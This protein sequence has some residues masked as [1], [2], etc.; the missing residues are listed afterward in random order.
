MIIFRPHR[1]MLSDAMSEAKEF[2]NEDEMKKHIVDQWG[3]YISV[4]DIVILD[5]P[6]NDERIGWKDT[7]LVCSRR[8]A[9]YIGMCATDY[10]RI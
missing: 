5:N 10:I 7:R 2:D 4:E 6:H 3:G 1:A 8:L 9:Q